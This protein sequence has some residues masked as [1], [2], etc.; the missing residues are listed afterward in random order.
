MPRETNVTDWYVRIEP[1]ERTLES[2]RTQAN[3][4]FDCED[5]LKQAR[6]HIDNLGYRGVM[7]DTEEVCSFCGYSWHENDPNYN[8]GCCNKDEANNPKRMTGSHSTQQ[9]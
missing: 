5:L 2:E 8:G 4:E 3:K 7:C 6:R 1:R 9:R